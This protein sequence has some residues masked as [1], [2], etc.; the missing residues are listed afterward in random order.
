MI[1]GFFFLLLVSASLK[2]EGIGHIKLPSSLLFKQTTTSHALLGYQKAEMDDLFGEFEQENRALDEITHSVD[3][4]NHSYFGLL[5]V[6]TKE[7]L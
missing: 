4:P 6:V 7:P 1:F 3:H 5:E 2:K